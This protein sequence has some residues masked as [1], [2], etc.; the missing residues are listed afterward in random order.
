MH[1]P[2]TLAQEQRIDRWFKISL[3]L[4]GGNAILEL[5]GGT[6]VLLTPPAFVQRVAG[7]FTE[8]E[9]GQ[10]PHDLVATTIRHLADLYVTGPQQIFIGAYLL[11]HGIVKFALVIGLLKNKAWAYPSALIVFTLFVVYQLYL[12][13]QHLSVWMFALTIFD[14]FIIY[15]V[16]REWQVVKAHGGAQVPS[17]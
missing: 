7:Y 16:W 14:L 5:I 10:D 3:L 15:F 11:S 2:P 6:L 12:L 4:K 13:A 8:E 1:E 17:A 9:L